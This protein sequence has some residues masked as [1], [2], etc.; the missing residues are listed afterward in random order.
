LGSAD[1]LSYASIDYVF[2]STHTTALHRLC[3][4]ELRKYRYR[5]LADVDLLETYSFDGL[6]VASS[7]KMALPD[8][9]H[10]S[11]KGY[12]PLNLHPPV[13]IEH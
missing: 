12:W 10:V 8:H 3:I 13:A 6:V 2:L 7:P 11:L 5:L 9:I 1:A 4:A